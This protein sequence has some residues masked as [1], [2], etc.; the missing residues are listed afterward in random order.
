MIQALVLDSAG[1]RKVEPVPAALRTVLESGESTL[2]VDVEGGPP[3]EFVALGNCFGFHPLAI[4]D[5]LGRA[6]QPKLDDYG[7][8]LYLVAHGLECDGRAQELRVLELDLFL[9]ANYVVT[10]HHEPLHCVKALWERTLRDGRY[11]QRGADGLAHAALDILVDDLMPVLDRLDATIEDLE[12]E[13][14]ANPTHR[15]LM[16]ILD[17]KRATLHMRRTIVPQREV[18]NRLGRDT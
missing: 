16:H 12:D 5:A 18:A 8:Y 4:E 17:V 14:L 6:E 13:I 11:Q 7:H 10:Y 2:W 1:V 15:T 3:E 9:G